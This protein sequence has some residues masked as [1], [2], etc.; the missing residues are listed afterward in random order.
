M[1]LRLVL[2]NEE[3]NKVLDSAEEMVELGLPLTDEE[4]TALIEQNRW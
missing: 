2:G 1:L 4:K 3:F